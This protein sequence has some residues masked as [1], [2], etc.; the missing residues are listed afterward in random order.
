[1]VTLTDVRALFLRSTSSPRLSDGA[2]TGWFTYTQLHAWQETAE[3]ESI[4]VPQLIEHECEHDND[5]Y[6]IG[7]SYNTIIIFIDQTLIL[8][9]P[10]PSR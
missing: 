7:A 5:T 4:Q 6:R 2:V 10:G 1:M 8:I 3:A 9:L